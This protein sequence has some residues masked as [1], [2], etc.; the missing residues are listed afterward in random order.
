[1]KPA[2]ARERENLPI[3][4]SSALERL[5]TLYGTA[6]LRTAYFYL[7]DRHLAED[8]SQE[9]FIRAYRNWSNFRGDSSTKTWLTKIT[10]NLC[11]DKLGLKSSSEEPT[12]PVLLQYTGQ[13]GV[14]EQAMKRMMNTAI[15]KQVMKL[16]THY[17]EVVY[18]YYYLELSTGEIAEATGTPE[19][20][21]RGRLHRARELLGTYLKKEG[22]T[23]AQN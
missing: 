20:T 7:G 15:L 2:G 8:I 5:M 16:P 1:M 12:D 6:V 11:R 19:G 9:V 4:P 18:L 14:E 3:E 13:S 10:I 17:H 23:D 21:V 22:L